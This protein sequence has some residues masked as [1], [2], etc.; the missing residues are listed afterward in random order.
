MEGKR[1]T[2]K[3]N[4]CTKEKSLAIGKT[5]K[6]HENEVRWILESSNR[7]GNGIVQSRV[8]VD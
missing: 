3:S 8:N 4:L 5:E 7:F 1:Y 2:K 6:E